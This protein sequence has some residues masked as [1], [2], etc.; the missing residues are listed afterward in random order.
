M[1]AHSTDLCATVGY[2]GDDGPSMGVLYFD[3]D[4]LGP[5]RR[6]TLDVDAVQVT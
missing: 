3:V 6:H 4:P 5:L 2:L 1:D